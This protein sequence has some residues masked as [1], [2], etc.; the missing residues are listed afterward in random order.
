MVIQDLIGSFGI[1]KYFV[2]FDAESLLID[3]VDDLDEVF[4]LGEGM[5]FVLVVAS[6]YDDD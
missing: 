1:G 5:F 2:E 3:V 6:F 4:E